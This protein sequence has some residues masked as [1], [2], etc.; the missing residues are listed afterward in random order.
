MA[1]RALLLVV[2]LVTLMTPTT[3]GVAASQAPSAGSGGLY[4]RFV[5]MVA[6]PAR[7]QLFGLPLD[8]YWKNRSP[9]RLAIV[10]NDNGTMLPVLRNWAGVFQRATGQ[11]FSVSTS[12]L[13]E[14]VTAAAAYAERQPGILFMVG[15]RDALTRLALARGMPVEMANRFEQSTWPMMFDFSREEKQRGLVMVA[16]DQN[17]R[18]I[19]SLMILAVVW[20]LGAPT[21]GQELEGVIEAQAGQPALTDFGRDLFALLYSPDLVHDMPLPDALERARRLTG[22]G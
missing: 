20:S 15:P 10:A 21:M 8:R 3:I 12:L 19:E 18:A 16:D 17:D 4:E 22:G 2:L 6:D 7:R 9:I 13:G 5:Q 1:R 11:I 14:D